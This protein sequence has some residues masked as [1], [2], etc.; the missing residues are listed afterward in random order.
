V[1]GAHRGK[2]GTTMLAGSR[3]CPRFAHRKLMVRARGELGLTV[4]SEAGRAPTETLLGL[5]KIPWVP[6]S[7]PLLRSGPPAEGCGVP[8][9]LCH[10]PHGGDP[11][12]SW[13]I[14]ARYLALLLQAHGPRPAPATEAKTRPSRGTWPARGWQATGSLALG[15]GTLARPAVGSTSANYSV[16]RP[17]AITRT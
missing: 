13:L 10:E 5:S 9:G 12:S 1:T 4:I 7:S 8:G 16:S 6:I 14:A 3:V 17:F 15:S 11:T 2:P